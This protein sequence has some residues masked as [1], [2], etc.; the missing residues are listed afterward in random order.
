MSAPHSPAL[1]GTLGALEIGTVVGTFLFGI[2]TLQT[3]NYYRQFPADSKKLKLTVAVLWLLELAHVICSLQ[4]IYLM[5]VTFYGQPTSEIILNPPQSHII[6]ILL[7]GG[8]DAIIFFGNR[9]RVLSGRSYVFFLCIALAILRVTIDIILM[10]SYWINKTGYADVIM[11][12]HWEVVTACAITPGGDMVIALSL[13]YHLWRVRKSEFN[14]T[15]NMVDT[16]MIWT[17]ETAVVTC[18]AGFLQLILFLS[19]KD[20]VFVAVFLMEPKL[21]SNAMLASLN[22]RARFRVQTES[23]N[24]G[25]SQWIAFE[26]TGA[27][28]RREDDH[29]ILSDTVPG[30]HSSVVVQIPPTAQGYNNT[31]GG[32]ELGSTR[33]HTTPNNASIHLPTLASHSP[34][35][36]IHASIA[37]ARPRMISLLHLARIF[38]SNHGLL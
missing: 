24:L 35:S 34:L 25:G 20:L 10:S 6:T 17:V 14:R 8:I 32:S 18:G 11:K 2:L 19:R 21:F 16:L 26:S 22:G 36:S 30:M 5:T 31:D 7:S 27:R 9:I 29:R 23:T 38:H 28:S 4:G 12:D 37:F 3:F 13:C 1:D 33:T 15:R